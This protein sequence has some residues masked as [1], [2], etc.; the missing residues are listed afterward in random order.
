MCFLLSLRLYTLSLTL[1][2][3]H[4]AKT[5][6]IHF[7]AFVTLTQNDRTNDEYY[8]IIDEEIFLAVPRRHS[9]LEELKRQEEIDLSLVKNEDIP[10]HSTK[11]AMV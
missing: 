1:H 2:L 6:S 7:L 10:L 9:R 11:P 4:I 8:P 5:N 3:Y